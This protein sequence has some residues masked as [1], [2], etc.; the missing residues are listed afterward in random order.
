[1]RLLT[2]SLIALLASGCG[3][4]GGG[5]V[6]SSPASSVSASVASPTASEPDVIQTR[7][8]V[9]L[10][11]EGDEYLLDVYAPPGPGPWPVVVAFHG[12]STAL[13]DDSYVT[14]VANAAA[15]AGMVVFVPSWVHGFSASVFPD[16][17]AGGFAA[18]ACALAF[19]QQEASG[20]GGDPARIVTYGFSAGAPEAAWLAL[21]HGTDVVDGCVAPQPAGLPVGAVLGDSEYFLH[22]QLFQKG[23]DTDP[24]GMLAHAAALVDPASWP[25]NVAARFHIWSAAA[26]TQSRTFDDPWDEDGWLAQRD[27]QGTIRTDLEVLGELDDG[28]ISFIDE[29]KL[30]AYRL[31]AAGLE[32]TVGLFPGGHVVFDKVP[33]L[34]AYLLDA[35]G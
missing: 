2:A 29:G 12:V 13:K 30:L 7:D 21:G 8:V 10:E 34:V 20:Y 6:S 14:V 11:R 1:M 35:A 31:E 16:D 18:S 9:Y 3:A 33:E 4:G 25:D 15:R 28:V 17:L 26:G 19:A 24:D 22:T 5:A 27:P 23:F 32:V